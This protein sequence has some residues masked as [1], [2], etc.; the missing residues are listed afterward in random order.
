MM[1]QLKTFEAKMV[2]RID[3]LKSELS[4]IRVGRANPAV[5]DKL[6]VDYYGTPTP[7][8][9]LAAVSVQEGKV[10]II[11]P[12][13][14]SLIRAIEKAILTSDLGINPN[15]D[16]SVIRLSF[17]PLTEE[18]R[19]EVTKSVHKYGEEAKVSIRNFR[20]EANDKLKELKK[21]SAVTE[22]E[23]KDGEDQIQ[24]VT[25]KHCKD[26]DALIAGKQ[27]EIMEL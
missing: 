13:D 2:K 19:R 14:K 10:L 20:R 27:K 26:I 4:T 12:W 25:E 7:V 8:Q 11:Q 3:G 22:D 9:Q 6:N 15:N 23:Q 17:P 24:K 21:S 18:H 5:L 16:G 1:E